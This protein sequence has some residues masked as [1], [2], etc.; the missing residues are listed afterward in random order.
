MITKEIAQKIWHCYNEIEQA[1]KMIAEM[2]ESLSADGNLEFKDNWNEMRDSLQLHIPSG[3]SSGSFF[4][5]NVSGEVALV[6]LQQHIEKHRQELER[7][8]VTCKIQ[9]A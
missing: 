2:K 5:R 7:L 8:K 3:K 1:E 6:V 9:L 4:V